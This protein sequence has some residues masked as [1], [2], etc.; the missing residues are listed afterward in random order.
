MISVVIIGA[1]NLSIH[2]FEAPDKAD[3]VSVIQWF[4]R[5]LNPIESYKNR[6]VITKDL[7]KLADADIYI[8]AFSL[9][10]YVKKMKLSY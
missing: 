7:T 8:D 2:F 5:K 3:Q 10:R 1:G 9:F 6:V 4:N